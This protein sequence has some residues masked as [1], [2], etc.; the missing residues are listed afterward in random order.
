MWSI[1]ARTLLVFVFWGALF[2]LA[3]AA[4]APQRVAELG[5]AVGAALTLIARAALTRTPERADLGETSRTSARRRA[6]V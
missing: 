5:C 2:A 4:G 3:L 1:L 6:S